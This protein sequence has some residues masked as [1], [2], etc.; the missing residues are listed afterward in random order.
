MDATGGTVSNPV[1]GLSI[2]ASI[3]N[4]C[5]LAVELLSGTL[6]VT[7]EGAP[8]PFA[9]VDLPAITLTGGAQ[10]MAIDTN[11]SWRGLWA[12]VFCLPKNNLGGRGWC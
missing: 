6:T 4:P 1:L 7:V 3:D 2:A 12:R 11:V 9:T 5:S 10:D 8:G